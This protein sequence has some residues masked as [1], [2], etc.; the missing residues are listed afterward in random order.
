MND[1]RQNHSRFYNWRTKARCTVERVV[2]T[3]SSA[4]ASILRAYAQFWGATISHVATHLINS[5]IHQSALVCT[6]AAEIL[7]DN[8]TKLDKRVR[9][10]CWGGACQACIHDAKCRAGL[11]K[12]LFE[13]KPEREIYLTDEGKKLFNI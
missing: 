4:E 11:Y 1:A 12:D 10:P 6:R 7:E 3:M 13:I 8:D 5:R 2:I 9:K